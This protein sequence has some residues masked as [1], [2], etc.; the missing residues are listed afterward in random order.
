MVYLC[1]PIRKICDGNDISKVSAALDSKALHHYDESENLH[2]RILKRLC[3]H[4]GGMTRDEI[5]EGF[6]NNHIEA[7][8]IEKWGATRYTVDIQHAVITFVKSIDYNW[9]YV[10]LNLED[11]DYDKLQAIAEDELGEK[12]FLTLTPDNLDE[13]KPLLE[14][15]SDRYTIQATEV[16][17]KQKLHVTVL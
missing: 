14:T 6:I 13:M 4:S 10:P 1:L 5:I 3:V 17:K 9:K 7:E 15:L 11:R 2:L 12:N 8:Q 16:R